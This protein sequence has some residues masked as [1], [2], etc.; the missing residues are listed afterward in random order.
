[1]TFI[2]CFLLAHTLHFPFTSLHGTF[3]GQTFPV[4]ICDNQHIVTKILI[5]GGPSIE[6]AIAGAGSVISLFV[7][8]IIIR[9]LE[10]CH[11]NDIIASYIF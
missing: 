6:V 5:I 3:E 7:S 11:Y 4:L 1:M 8:I 10:L 9:N 2:F